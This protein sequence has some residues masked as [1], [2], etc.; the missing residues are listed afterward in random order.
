MLNQLIKTLDQ[1]ENKWLPR[2]RTAMR[3][4]IDDVK[5][6]AR[7]EAAFFQ[8]LEQQPEG[9]PVIGSVSLFLTRLEELARSSEP[10]AAEVVRALE[11]IG[12][13]PGERARARELIDTARKEAAAATP[14]PI[15]PAVIVA[16]SRRQLEAFDKLNRWYIHWAGV[17]RDELPYNDA[18]RLGII[19][20]KGGRSTR[21]MVDLDAD[22]DEPSSGPTPPG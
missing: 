2:T 18:L 3:L 19:A 8:D 13:T 4:A 11:R 6:R 14:A 17:L 5:Q 20:Q 10:G 1:F 16:A 9:A 21:A 12:L 22:L 7:L 15:D